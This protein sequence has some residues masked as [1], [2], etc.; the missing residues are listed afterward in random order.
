MQES[1]K[2]F[3]PNTCRTTRGTEDPHKDVHKPNTHTHT[4]SMN[5]FNHTSTHKHTHWTAHTFHNEWRWWKLN[6]TTLWVMNGTTRGVWGEWN[7]ESEAQTRWVF[8]ES[9]WIIYTRIT[10]PKIYSRQHGREWVREMMWLSTEASSTLL[11]PHRSRLDLM[12]PEEGE[13]RV[14]QGGED[15]GWRWGR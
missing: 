15:G 12:D 11:H 3:T 4:A 14:R 2:K 6:P 13:E 1:S 8:P 7:A 5:S 10:E 9:L